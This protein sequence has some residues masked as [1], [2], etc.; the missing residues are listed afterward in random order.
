MLAFFIRVVARELVM[1][2]GVGS[3]RD[4]DEPVLRI[5]LDDEWRLPHHLGPRL[6]YFGE[7]MVQTFP[8]GHDRREHRSNASCRRKAGGGH[9]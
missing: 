7:V 9:A 4:E 2:D 8:R 6:R 5:N 3:R 1:S